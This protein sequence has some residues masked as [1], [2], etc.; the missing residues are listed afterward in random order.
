[1]DLIFSIVAGLASI[2]SIPLALYFYHKTDNITQDKARKDIVKT[3]S[4]K[5]G[6]ANQITAYDICSVYN[7][8]IREHNISNPTFTRR[9]VLDDLKTEIIA[10][11]LLEMHRRNDILL[12]LDNIEFRFLSYEEHY[13]RA[14]TIFWRLMNSPFR[15]LLMSIF[16]IL[17]ITPFLLYLPALI[18]AAS[19]P[20]LDYYFIDTELLLQYISFCVQ[21]YCFYIGLFGLVLLTLIYIPLKIYVKKTAYK[22]EIL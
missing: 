5:L 2:I 19:T 11:P 18:S 9:D 1:M 17:M 7:S 14:F 4:Y 6:I 10:N 16:S 13:G 3:L 12:C 22:I 15:I 8:K 21:N 20:L